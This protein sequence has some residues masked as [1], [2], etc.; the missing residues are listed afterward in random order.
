[1]FPALI[2][3]VQSGQNQ[4][5]DRRTEADAH[6]GDVADVADDRDLE[7]TLDELDERTLRHQAFCTSDRVETLQLQ[8]QRLFIDGEANLRDRDDE[9]RDTQDDHDRSGDTEVE[10]RPVKR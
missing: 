2:G 1:M 9:C 7:E 8:A 3:V 4:E 5:H 6:D 10:A